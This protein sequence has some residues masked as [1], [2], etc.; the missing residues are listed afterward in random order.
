MT[1]VSAYDT[2]QKTPEKLEIG[3]LIA[4]YVAKLKLENFTI[5]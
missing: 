2:T 3:E 4:H 5:M 1:P